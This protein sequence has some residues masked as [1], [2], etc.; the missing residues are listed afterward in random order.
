ME[1]HGRN[2]KL[3]IKLKLAHFILDTNRQSD[4]IRCSIKSHICKW[5]MYG[6]IFIYF[7]YNFTVF[8]NECL[9]LNS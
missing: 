8:K 9:D 7:I 4:N 6:V 3:K 5:Q 1:S 2:R